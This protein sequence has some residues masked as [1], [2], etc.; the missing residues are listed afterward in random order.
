MVNHQSVLLVEAVNAVTS[1][2]ITF[3][4]TRTHLLREPRF[5]RRV[6][7]L[8]WVSG[9]LTRRFSHCSIGPYNPARGH[10]E[11][12]RISR[13]RF[14][15]LEL[16]LNN[17]KGK[18]MGDRGDPIRSAFKCRNRGQIHVDGAAAESRPL[19]E[20]ACTPTTSRSR[21]Q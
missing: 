3:F 7:L 9:I 10:A 14:V 1:K 8:T 4:D 6:P 13:F 15:G 16:G 17:E 20:F 11:Y 18:R 21:P 12:R 5:S 2:G 19:R